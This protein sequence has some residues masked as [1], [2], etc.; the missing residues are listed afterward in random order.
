MNP[1]YL[2]L[3]IIIIFSI[4]TATG[5][6]PYFTQDLNKRTIV[7]FGALILAIQFLPLWWAP[8]VQY[9]EFQIH[10]NA[11]L[12]MLAAFLTIRGDEE[13]SYK[14]YLILC[15][16]LIAAI[17]GLLRKMYSFDP[18]FYWIDPIW[19]APLLG[20]VLC[21]A[22]ASQAKHQFGMIVW[23]AVLGELLN[24]ALQ[25]HRHTAMI[26]SLAWWDSFWI[27]FASARLFSMLL[28]WL[29]FAMN[30]LQVLFWHLK[31]GRSS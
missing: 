23:G 17:W 11:G 24:A 13:R 8:E 20:G 16:L 25:S 7:F 28:K 27:A 30:K 1:G 12:L 9:F 14:G 19:D 5:W 10:V 15:A 6:K 4:L 29:Q 22:F 26:G 31:G 21:G 18:V 3:W 2:S